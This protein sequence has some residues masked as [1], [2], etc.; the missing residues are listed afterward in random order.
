M[1]DNIKTGNTGS[2]H[3]VGPKHAVRYPASFVRGSIRRYGLDRIAQRLAW[4]SNGPSPT[5]AG[6]SPLDDYWGR[7]GNSRK[8]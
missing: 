7:S 2:Y 6:S 8:R 1:L 4:Q 3:P 5:L